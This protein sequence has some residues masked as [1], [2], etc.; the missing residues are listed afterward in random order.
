VLLRFGELGIAASSNG[1]GDIDW[2]VEFLSP[3]FEP[4]SSGCAEC[5][6]DLRVDE[7]AYRELVE[8]GPA[9]GGAESALF[10]FDNS[11]VRLPVWND[12]GRREDAAGELV[13]L[14][15]TTQ[16]I[17]RISDHGRG[18]TTGCNEATRSRVPSDERWSRTTI[19]SAVLS[20]RQQAKRRAR[21]GASLKQGRTRL[22]RAPRPFPT[23]GLRPT[24]FR[25]S[26]PPRPAQ[27][28]VTRADG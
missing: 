16:C 6:V 4:V 1:E 26:G 5:R 22:I 10:A 13:L 25:D 7:S 14:D 21:A 3:Q 15:S 11:V 9:A 12:G 17:Y 18:V 19:S 20:C 23:P 2:L 24:A 27:G 28:W 8:A